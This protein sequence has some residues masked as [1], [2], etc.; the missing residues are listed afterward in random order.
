METTTPREKPPLVMK[1]GGTSVASAERIA[2]AASLV[3]REPGLVVVVTSAM[4]GVTDELI[5]LGEIA[6][7]RR[8]S[9]VEEGLEELRQ[10]HLT[11]AQSL[12]PDD[13][14]QT[15]LRQT[16]EAL[17]TELEQ[18]LHGV[19]LLHELSPRSMDLLV[20]FGERLCAPMLAAAVARAGSK[21]GEAV[22]ARELILTTEAHGTNESSV[23]DVPRS[24]A[25]SRSV[26]LER[27]EQV[28][29]VVTGFIART[30]DGHTTTLG[31][32]GSDYTASLIGSFLDAA[33]IWIWT[34]VDGV[35][36][37]D[38]R[39]VP[40]A[41]VLPSITYR[42]AAEMAYFGSK[43]LHP[44]T[45]I[46]AV[47]SRIP[48]R[49]RN[50]FNPDHLGTLIAEESAESA[51]GVKSV[52]SVADLALITVEGNG[53][54][55]VPGVARRVFASTAEARVNVYMVSQASSEHNISFVVGRRQGPA[56]VRALERQFE[57]ELSRGLIDRIDMIT[58][59]GILAVIGEGMKGTPGIA[60]RLFTALGRGRINVLAIAQ[61]SSELNLSVVVRQPE[62][63]RAVGAAHSR[64]GLTRDTHLLL[65]GKGLVGRTLLRQIVEARSRLATEHGVGLQVMGICGRREMLFEE[66][67]VDD[68]RLRRVAEGVSLL[69]IGGEE[70]PSDSEIFQRIGTSRWLDVVLVDA[71]AEDNGALHAEALGH[72]LHVV[73]ANKKPMS[74]PL[75]QYR[76]ILDRAAQHGLEYHFE[77]TF[78]AG[79]PALSTL[80]ELIG[81]CDEVNRVTGCFSGT[82]GYLCA[83]RAAAAPLLRS[84][85]RG[86]GA[87]LHRT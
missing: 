55:G 64:F 8:T 1:F 59:V 2:H 74:G 66:N 53:M 87:R 75:H 18:L 82:L 38:P 72:G 47:Q 49:I 46:P 5:R 42:E 50:T 81:T 10:R 12:L 3:V 36:T 56:V 27:L 37:A 48:V 23:V 65:F 78:A 67:G 85:A 39:I 45:M 51:L 20:S 41:R 6:V 24:R 73:T 57:L 80:R 77:T 52:T 83:A 58:S 69:E 86:G 13:A 62:L 35:M 31:R 70:R 34:D 29:P 25:L 17:L 7:E 71:T 63:R 9:D 33:A 43:V 19:S 22:D 40:E 21:S 26:L 4:G 76:T 61:G 54:V 84:G 11:A 16:V 44:S 28:I 60:Q 32:G 30:P 68:E 79:L 14:A 15:A